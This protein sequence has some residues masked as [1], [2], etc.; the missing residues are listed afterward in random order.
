MS[1]T[2]LDV[3]RSRLVKNAQY[4]G[5]IDPRINSSDWFQDTFAFTATNAEIYN[6]LSLVNPPDAFALLA[7][8]IR[9]EDDLRRELSARNALDVI[10]PR[11]ELMDVLI[12]RGMDP[13]VAADALMWTSYDVRGISHLRACVYSPAYHADA[14]ELC[15]LLSQSHSRS[16]TLEAPVIAVRNSVLEGEV[17]LEAV[18]ALVPEVK[19]LSQIGTMYAATSDLNAVPR[20]YDFTLN[21]LKLFARRAAADFYEI[22]L[23]HLTSIFAIH[24]LEVMNK[25]ESLTELTNYVDRIRLGDGSNQTQEA[26]AEKYGLAIRAAMLQ[27]AVT[28]HRPF[29]GDEWVTVVDDAQTLNDSGVDL[30]DA[31]PYLVKGVPAR[32]IRGILDGLPQGI[33]EGWL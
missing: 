29:T 14:I 30:D 3:P 4:W 9:T 17:S 31:T 12:S 26:V 13:I 18:K 8:G 25:V 27:Q 33:A 21:D 15:V 20:E 1:I 6:M 2:T 11:R 10:F 5:Y 23:A 22:S 28:A 24:G 19:L 7:K 16:T 32:K